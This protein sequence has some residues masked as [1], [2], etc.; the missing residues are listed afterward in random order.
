MAKRNSNIIKELQQKNL[1]YFEILFKTYL[2][3]LGEKDLQ[4]NL[5]KSLK[6][7]VREPIRVRKV[8]RRLL[9][10]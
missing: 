6:N 7:V 8:Q 5:E 9:T 3:I 2:Q 1:P 10:K 4:K